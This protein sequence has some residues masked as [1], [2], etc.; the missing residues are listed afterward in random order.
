MAVPDRD[1]PPPVATKPFPRADALIVG[2]SRFGGDDGAATVVR[3]RPCTAKRLHCRTRR[4]T[5]GRHSRGS[6]RGRRLRRQ[7]PTRWSSRTGRVPEDPAGFLRPQCPDLDSAAN[8]IARSLRLLPALCDALAVPA[9]SR[10]RF[11]NVAELPRMS[12]SRAPDSHHRSG[13]PGLHRGRRTRLLSRRCGRA[14]GAFRSSL[15]FY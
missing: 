13:V 2:G 14:L 1:V 6:E 3:D 9:A 8:V 4:A 5:G 15:L 7:G 12:S 10:T 11:R